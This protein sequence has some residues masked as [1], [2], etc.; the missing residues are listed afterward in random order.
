[1]GGRRGWSG[2]R[3]RGSDR[4]SAAALL[5]QL[6]SDG[7]TPCVMAV[8]ELHYEQNLA[9]LLR[10]ADATGI[11]ALVLPP[12]RS[13]KGITPA[14]RSLAGPAAD[15]IPIVREGLMSALTTMRRRGLL[16]IGATESG[17]ELYDAID[18]TGATAFVLGGED[19]GVTAAVE[20]KCDALVRLPLHGHVSSLNVAATAAVLAFER[21]RQMELA[22]ATAPES[23]P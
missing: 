23:R 12:S 21:R 19:K 5:D 4:L 16:V 15:R 18:Y 9:N 7:V 8:D 3:G 10:L 22:A 17:S 2:G 6:E 1:M 11:H 14:V 13:V 20:R